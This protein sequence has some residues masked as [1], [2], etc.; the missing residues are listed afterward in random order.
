MMHPHAILVL[1]LAL[2]VVAASPGGMEAAAQTDAEP[3]VTTWRVDAAGGNVTIPVG[4]ASGT[5]T[6]YWGDG[7]VDVDVTGTQ[8]HTYADTGNYTIS[9]S[10][11]FTRIHLDGQP[12]A[13]KLLSIDQWGD[14]QW[15]S[16]A[17]AFEG[18]S[19]MVYNAT[20]SPDL[21]AVTNMSWMFAGATSFNGDLSS[22]DTSSVTDMSVMF[23]NA[24]SFNGNIS[25]WDTS[26]V[27][28]MS[29]MFADTSSFNGDI[30]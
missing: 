27:T 17:S 22:W 26:S 15:E 28:D 11:D 18:A 9:I 12:N 20:D 5:Y 4:G 29:W 21:S 14:M 23:Y 7:T 1:L 30:S 13:L 2:V 25:K 3:F 16:M 8:N 24:S 10:G 6:V 19:D